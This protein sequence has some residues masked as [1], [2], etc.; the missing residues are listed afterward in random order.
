MDE[1]DMDIEARW[2]ME[3]L[4][5]LVLMLDSFDGYEETLAAEVKRIVCEYHAKRIAAKQPAETHDCPF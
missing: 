1:G 2:C 3:D 4:Y 5:Y